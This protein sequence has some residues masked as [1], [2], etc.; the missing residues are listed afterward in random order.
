MKNNAFIFFFLFGITF[1]FSQPKTYS[2]EQAEKL[3][4]ENPKPYFIF[5]KT[6][7][8][9]FCKMMEKSTFKNKAVISI[10]NADFYFVELNAEE[11][12]DITFN[13]K[14]FKFIP[15]GINSGMHRLA[16]ELANINGELSYPTTVILNSNF[17]IIGKKSGFI[18]SKS[19]LSLLS[20][21]FNH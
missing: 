10:L 16:S 21:T 11:K 2:F 1:G 6:P 19:L 15:N 5:I 8:C 18:D 13:G 3:A 17:E 14:I 12:K 7:W 20:N 4:V 9:K